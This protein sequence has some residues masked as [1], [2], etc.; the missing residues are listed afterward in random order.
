[1]P[2]KPRRSNAVDPDVKEVG[3]TRL[4][5]NCGGV[6][7]GGDDGRLEA[8]RVQPADQSDGRFENLDAVPLQA[9]AEELVLAVAEPSHGLRI[10]RVLRRAIRQVDEARR[11]EAAYAVV[12]RFTVYIVAVITLDVERSKRLSRAT[13]APLQERVEKLLPG[14]GVHGRGLGDDAVQIKH[15]RIERT[16]VDVDSDRGSLRHGAQVSANSAPKTTL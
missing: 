11:E 9:L 10:R 5:Q 8:H 4:S 12:S 14:S 6:F 15:G 13:G 2:F 16:G 7:A 1:L 3:E